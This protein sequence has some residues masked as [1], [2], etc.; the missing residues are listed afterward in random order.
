[1]NKKLRPDHDYR[2]HVLRGLLR[3]CALQLAGAL[4]LSGMSPAAVFAADAWPNPLIGEWRAMGESADKYKLPIDVIYSPD[5][6]FTA[7]M[8]WGAN[9]ETGKGA[10]TQFSRGSWR[11]TGPNSIEVIYTES[12]MCAAGVGCVPSPN[13]LPHLQFTFRMNGPNEVT[14]STGMT[15]YRVR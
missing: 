5:G 10:G 7:S 15:A 14:D 12:K 2:H 11:M 4:L 6:T 3:G 9:R 8:S 1:M 13:G